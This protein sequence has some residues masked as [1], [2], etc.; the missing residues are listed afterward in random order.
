[1]VAKKKPESVE[2]ATISGWHEALEELH[3]RV[4]HHFARRSESG[5]VATWLGCLGG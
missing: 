5:P 3:A 2:S 4:A 1:M